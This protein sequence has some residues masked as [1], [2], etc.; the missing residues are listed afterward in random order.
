MSAPNN[1]LSVIVRSPA[2]L[3]QGGVFVQ[4]ILGLYKNAS[5]SC[6]ARVCARLFHLVLRCSAQPHGE[7]TSK[8]QN[9]VKSRNVA[10]ERALSLFVIPA[11]AG[12]QFC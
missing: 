7:G 4:A 10:L 3:G 2:L 12:I 8:A 9:N 11:Q 5:A 6:L 1:H